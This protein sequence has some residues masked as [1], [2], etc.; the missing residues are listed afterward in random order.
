MVHLSATRLTAS[1]EALLA[2]FDTYLQQAFSAGIEAPDPRFGGIPMYASRLTPA[3]QTEAKKIF[4]SA[5]AAWL[6]AAQTP[7]FGRDAAVPLRE[8]TLTAGSL[9]FKNGV[10][11][12]DVLPA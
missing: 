4:R 3:Q 6:L 9:T 7:R 2:A 5:F 11:T 8:L 1:Q 10:L 12:H